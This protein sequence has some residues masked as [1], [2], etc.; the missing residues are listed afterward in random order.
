MSVQ[1]I[2]PNIWCQGTAEHAAEF[3][4]SA[5]PAT[6][7]EVE[8]RYP[9]EGLLD[10]QQP[11]AG[12]PLTV[13]VSVDG[14]Q[15]T[16]INAGPEFRPNRSL[17]LMLH[18]DP[19]DYDAQDPQLASRAAH[20]QLDAT[21][22]A[23]AEGGEVLMP[24]GEY[25]FS[26]RYG[27]LADRYGVNWQVMLVAPDSDPRPF[28]IPSLLF[29]S[30]AQN[31]AGE[32]IDFYVDVFEGT[33]LG[34]LA[35]YGEQTG[36]ATP[37][38][39]MY[40]EFRIGAQWFAAMDSG[41]EQDES[42]SCG[43]SLEVKCRDQAEIDRLWDAL[44]AV[45]EAEQCGWLADRFGVSWQIVPQQMGELMERPNAFSNLLGMKKLIIDEL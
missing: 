22:D 21:W 10:F 42:F 2:V 41:V 29:G 32:A 43:M 30:D 44:S 28:V 24:L 15:L 45:P 37:D 31:R 27:W 19:T 23:L 25:P 26:E 9:S 16:L 3:Y 7:F 4:A 12:Q 20:A 36:P 34:Q 33:E 18:F 38:A 1:K 14:Y 5:L 6:T 40:G 8:S 11:L 35:P 13:T 17:S 39:L